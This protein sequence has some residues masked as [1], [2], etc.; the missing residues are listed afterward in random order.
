KSFLTAPPICLGYQELVKRAKSDENGY[1]FFQGAQNLSKRIYN[2]YFSSF[3]WN[4]LIPD[5]PDTLTFTKGTFKTEKWYAD[6]Y[7]SL[8]KFFIKENLFMEEMENYATKKYKTLSPANLYE[9]AGI[10]PEKNWIDDFLHNSLAILNNMKLL[11]DRDF[12][13]PYESSTYFAYSALNSEM[14]L[15]ELVNILLLLQKGDYA[16]AL[17][18][19]DTFNH[20]ALQLEPICL[21]ASSQIAQQLSIVTMI[22]SYPLSTDEFYQTLLNQL[23]EMKEKV[24]TLEFKTVYQNALFYLENSFV[25]KQ[26]EYR[27]TSPQRFIPRSISMFFA[28]NDISR[29]LDKKRKVFETSTWRDIEDAV[30]Y[31]KGKVYNAINTIKSIKRRPLSDI[32]EYWM[33]W[34]GE[35]YKIMLLR[36]NHSLCAIYG[37]ILTVLLEKYHNQKGVY[38]EDLYDV[39]ENYF[40]EEEL[41]WIDNYLDIYLS[42]EKYFVDYY[43]IPKKEREALK[44]SLFNYRKSYRVRSF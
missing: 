27:Y 13:L 41:I 35:I 20:S 30:F 6:T 17:D 21:W 37:S 11:N 26:S 16:N 12:F 19:I 5:T 9:R 7:L 43:P 31:N 8:Y 28:Y 29:V 15:I 40:T 1:L 4:V 39:M 36:Y 42:S 23:S 14:L 3:A 24:K 34:S 44:S 25:L 10:Y 2:G 33:F 18:W 38:P 22:A 32:E